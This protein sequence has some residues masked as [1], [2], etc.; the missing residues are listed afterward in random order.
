LELTLRQI[1]NSNSVNPREI[2]FRL[3]QYVSHR[4][5]FQLPGG[6]G[7]GDSGD[8]ECGE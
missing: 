3:V 8:K 6:C 2:Q 7:G 4:I 5:Q 1:T